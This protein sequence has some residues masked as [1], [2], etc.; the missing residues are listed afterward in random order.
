M[1]FKHFEFWSLFVLSYLGSSKSY[2]KSVGTLQTRIFQ[3][4][5]W[6]NCIQIRLE[7]KKSYEFRC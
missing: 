1:K 6:K 3:G 7:I 4:I 2:N 5:Q